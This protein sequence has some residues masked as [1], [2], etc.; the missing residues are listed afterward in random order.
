MLFWAIL[1]QYFI[2]VF[3]WLLCRSVNDI[4]FILSR[5]LFDLL[6][7]G[8][9]LDGIGFIRIY[10][11]LDLLLLLLLLRLVIVYLLFVHYFIWFRYIQ[12][13]ICLVLLP[14]L[15]F[16]V[17]TFRICLPFNILSLFLLLRFVFIYL[18]LINQV[19]W[20]RYF[21]VLLCLV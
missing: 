21:Q 13:L 6:F 20:V 4:A 2:C 11:F 19:I 14:F 15:S 5:F 16:R 8:L 7:L 1:L 18:L 3:R 10:L 12:F 17:A 9:S